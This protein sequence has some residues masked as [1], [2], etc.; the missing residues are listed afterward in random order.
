MIILATILFILLSPGLLVTIP[1]AGNL[2][3]SETTSNLAV[4]VHAVAF[5]AI[6]KIVYT[7]TFGLGWILNIESEITGSASIDTSTK[8]A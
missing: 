3:M 4:I 5:F 2:W 1:P 7:N 8:P 6:L